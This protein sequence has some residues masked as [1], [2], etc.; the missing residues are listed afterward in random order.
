MHRRRAQGVVSRLADFDDHAGQVRGVDLDAGNLGPGKI[1]AYGDRHEFAF[2]M[3]LAPH[4]L[5]IARRQ[6]N[7]QSDCIESR[8]DVICLLGHQGNPVVVAVGRHGLALAVQDTPPWR[9]QKLDVDAVVIGQHYIAVR[10]QNLQVIEPPDQRRQQQKLTAREHRGTT[11]IGLYA[12]EIMMRHIN[13]TPTVT[14][15]AVSG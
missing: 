10:L 7:Q 8:R 5:I 14:E 12:I 13:I 1:L 3:D 2:A 6:G 15:D 4:P 9:R 11:V